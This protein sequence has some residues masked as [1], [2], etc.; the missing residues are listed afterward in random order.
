M[1]LQPKIR[2]NVNFESQI[3]IRFGYQT[4]LQLSN[5]HVYAERLGALLEYKC[6]QNNIA[7]KEIKMGNGYFYNECK[8]ILKT[9]MFLTGDVKEA[10]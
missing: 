5:A 10:G 7:L 8:K 6:V 3:E 4:M 9:E 1:P 2:Q